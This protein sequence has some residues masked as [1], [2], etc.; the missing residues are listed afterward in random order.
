MSKLYR[1]GH[2]LMVELV[3]P[4]WFLSLRFL[5][6]PIL[7]LVP[8][9]ILNF[10]QILS[11]F[12]AFSNLA[13]YII[14]SIKWSS[15]IKYHYVKLNIFVMLVFQLVLVHYCNFGSKCLKKISNSGY[16]WNYCLFLTLRC[17]ISLMFVILFSYYFDQIFTLLLIQS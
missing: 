10:D 4:L 14:I 11:N 6:T 7:M 2:P 1:L 5:L 3:S 16:L 15:P 8:I 12:H 17:H 9:K 13:S